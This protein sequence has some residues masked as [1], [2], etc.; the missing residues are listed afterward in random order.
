MSIIVD[1]WLMPEFPIENET[2]P[3][4]K[5][6]AKID[7]VSSLSDSQE[8]LIAI[9]L[10]CSSILSIIGSSLIV[11]K[12]IRLKLYTKPYDRLMLALSLSDIIASITYGILTPLL[13]PRDVTVFSYG[14]QRT[15]SILGFF[16]QFSF[17]CI[18]YNCILSFYHLL[19]LR[20]KIKKHEFATRYE[21]P[22]HIFNI[23]YFLITAAVGVIYGFYSPVDIGFGCWVN[24]FPKGCEL[25]GDCISQTI[26]L[27]YAAFPV[28]VTFVALVLN[29]TIIYRYVRSML[30]NQ[31]PSF[32]GISSQE[33]IFA[34]ENKH[35]N[36]QYHEEQLI[37]QVAT[38]GFLYVASFLF[39]YSPAMTMRGIESFTYNFDDAS[40][41]PLLVAAAVSLPLQGF[42]NMFIYNRPA[43]VRIR[44]A[45]PDV[46]VFQAISRACVESNTSSGP[47]YLR[48]SQK[49]VKSIIRQKSSRNSRIESSLEAIQEGSED[50]EGRAEDDLAKRNV[51]NDFW[52]D[53]VSSILESIE[54]SALN[55]ETVIRTAKMNSRL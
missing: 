14:N 21:K 31:I 51:E 28:F 30:N 40:V 36:R 25:T 4:S 52:G 3:S 12:V 45:N 43:F 37:R 55:P 24:D 29:N 26:G 48:Q 41:F 35:N 33:A 32:A 54:E 38:Q 9:L 13:M 11:Y 2:E 22:M 15:C 8:A 19:T 10:L 1:D 47:R 46:T 39:C 53:A 49:I 6:D 7:F 50:E 44:V 27:I 20:Y 17:T 23:A 34:R 18:G 16:T 42:L 5:E